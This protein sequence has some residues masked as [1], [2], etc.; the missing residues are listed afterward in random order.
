MSDEI[1]E[2]VY[3]LASLTV[4]FSSVASVLAITCF[5]IYARILARNPTKVFE[6]TTK[7]DIESSSWVLVLSAIGALAS[8]S[9][10]IV[11]YQ[12]GPNCPVQTLACNTQ[13]GQYGA[14]LVASLAATS[15]AIMKL[16]SLWYQ[17][18]R[19]QGLK[20]ARPSDPTRP[21]QV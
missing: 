17:L 10:V 7:Y 14:T 5:T 4:A 3:V 16:A 9:S 13:M 21:F 1:C 20:S 18:H 2:G 11:N 8:A 6:N 12:C 15:A 19:V